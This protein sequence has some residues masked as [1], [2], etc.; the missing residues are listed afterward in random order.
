MT[1]PT[2]NKPEATVVA[3]NYL[4]LRDKY[5]AYKLYNPNWENLK[6]NTLKTNVWELFAQPLVK[7]MV[8][9]VQH[10]TVSSVINK[11]ELT[12]LD[13]VHFQIDCAADARAAKQYNVVH[14]C[15]KEVAKLL[16]HYGQ[17]TDDAIEMK[18]TVSRPTNA[19]D[20][21]SKP[22]QS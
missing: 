1:L 4:R 8:A 22:D 7:L 20:K 19:L 13:L 15:G 21:P 9:D 18:L 5:E 3:V 17:L 2:L 14:A 6:H 12:L 10:S 16:N 11:Y